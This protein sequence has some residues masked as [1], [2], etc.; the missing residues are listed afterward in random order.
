VQIQFSEPVETSS[1]LNVANYAISPFVQ[2]KNAS[3]SQN[4][5]TVTLKTEPHAEGTYQLTINNVRDRAQVPNEILANSSFN[6]QYVDIFAPELVALNVLGE[7]HLEIRFNEPVTKSSAED[8]SNYAITP[9]IVLQSAS[10]QNDN[11]AVIL[12]TSKHLEG[13]YS[14]Y[15]VGITDRAANPNTIRQ[16][17][18]KNYQYV[19][20]IAPEILSVEAPKADQVDVFFN[21]VMDRNSAENKANYQISDGIVV[22]SAILDVDQM[23]VHL[24]TTKH[25]PGTYNITV[26]NVRD[27]SSQ[28]NSIATNT[29]I[30]YQYIDLT[31]PEVIAVE[32]PL[33]NQVDVT[34]S[35]PVEKI[36]AENVAN[37]QIDN[38]IQIYSAV[39]DA[40]L[41]V[42]HLQTSLHVPGNYNL[43]VQNIRDRAVNPN[44][45][46]NIAN[47]AYTYV[48]RTPP[49]IMNVRALNDTTVEVIFSEIVD[50]VSSQIKS[51]YIINNNIQVFSA[52]LQ[53]D[54]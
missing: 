41:S 32:A 29:Q 9:G 17:I 8:L 35:E 12:E 46:A 52:T 11:K 37:Y 49:Q 34:F 20:F 53:S 19:D 44:Q 16:T 45:M 31:P 30:S 22:N 10:L 3:L 50:P 42:V 21:E 33:E 26:S 4:L 47:F 24:A 28:K 48:D 36:S 15:V 14:L 5:K 18:S 23:V 54:E 40:N 25:V 13:E 6:Y 43:T 27:N 2:I 38:G 51:N 7:N 1:A 39:L